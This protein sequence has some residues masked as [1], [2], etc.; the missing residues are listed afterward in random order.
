VPHPVLPPLV[1]HRFET[2]I[3]CAAA[4]PDG[5]W[6]AASGDTETVYVVGSDGGFLEPAA[7]ASLAL[8]LTRR[9]RR[10]N[11]QAGSQYCVWS[12]DGMR[13]AASSDTLHAVAVWAAPPLGAPAEFVPLA[14]FAEFPR[15][16]LALTFLPQTADGSH[17][18][19]WSELDSSVY[20][21]DVD[22]AAASDAWA[23]PLFTSC[24]DR[25][26]RARGVQRIRLPPAVVPPPAGLLLQ[27]LQALAQGLQLNPGYLNRV[28]GLCCAG[29]SLFVAQTMVVTKWPILSEWSKEQHSRFP[30]A[31]R[32]AARVL[33]LGASQEPT[34]TDE[35]ALAAPLPCLPKEIVVQII[36]LAA[37]P[38][39]CWLPARL[40]QEEEDNRSE[41]RRYS[42]P[43]RFP[44]LTEDDMRDDD[45]D[46][47]LTL[48]DV[49]AGGQDVDDE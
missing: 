10:G 2:A 44:V 15:P 31:F 9:Q 7:C 5:R 37:M 35:S 25:E 40:S 43:G 4:S 26:M 34:P 23:R 33:L 16:A 18:L 14:R 30:V 27:E 1:R 24:G 11:E 22:H 47:V 28:T 32:R 21:A 20:V 3:N 17:L 36:A 13:L 42:Y 49:S 41:Q 46:D 29:G 6:L 12:A 8:R 38:R 45:D 39:T 19:A 48:G